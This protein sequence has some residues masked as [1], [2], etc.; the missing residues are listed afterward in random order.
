[1]QSMYHLEV[2][3]RDPT[4]TCTT[5]W[6]YKE[7]EGYMCVNGMRWFQVGLLHMFITRQN[8]FS[9]ARLFSLSQS[10]NLWTESDARKEASVHIF[11]FHQENWSVVPWAS[12]CVFRHALSSSSCA[13]R[14]QS[15]FDHM[16]RVDWP[17]LMTASGQSS[18]LSVQ[19]LL[20]LLVECLECVLS[21]LLLISFQ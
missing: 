19:P 11:G 9:A 10:I 1:M 8:S 14:H 21:C 3:I 6:S 17:P 16:L 18:S 5:E 20:L 13:V 4:C 2:L 7:T 12:E 15:T